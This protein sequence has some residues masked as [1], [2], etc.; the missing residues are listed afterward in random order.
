MLDAISARQITTK[1][2]GKCPEIITPYIEHIGNKIE[3]AAK[4][5]R[6]M[7]NNPFYGLTFSIPCPSPEI[8]EAVRK[9]LEE[10]GY[11]WEIFF[12]KISFLK[13]SNPDDPKS[14]PYDS[15][16]W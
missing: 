11:T 5:G 6:R 15:I 12:P 9:A 7:I 16:S 3:E 4:Q 10:K 13:F 2:L 1:A 14:Q 8:R